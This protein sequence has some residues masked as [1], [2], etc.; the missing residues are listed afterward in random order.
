M[1]E[2]ATV[3]IL[4]IRHHGPGSAQSVAEA[5]DEIGPDCILVEG[6][7]ELT[8]ILPLLADPDTVPPIAGLVYDAA[9]PRRASFYPLASFSPEWVATRWGL[10]HDVPVEWTDLPAAA[11]LAIRAAVDEAGDR[12]HSAATAES[13]HDEPGRDEHVVDPIG[14]LAAAAGYDEPER[15]WEDAVEHRG[16][17]A[18]E[19][20]DGVGRPGVV[21][22]FDAVREAIAE[23]RA[24]EPV[25][26]P[27]VDDE[28]VLDLETASNQ[29]GSAM[30]AVREAAMRKSLRAALKAGRLRIAVVCGAWHAPALDPARMPSA[31]ADNRLLRGLPKT[32]VAAAWVPWTAT[33]LSQ[34]SGYGAGVASP[35]WYRHLF[36]ARRD[37]QDTGQA[38][39]SWMVRVARELRTQGRP[40]SPAAVVDAVRLADSLATLRGRPHPGLAELDDAALSVLADGDR[41]PLSLVN[42]ALVVG[43][44]VGAVPESAPLVPLAADLQRLQ[45]SCRLRPAAQAKSVMLDLRTDSGRAK[46]VLLHRLR[47][48]GIT[49]GLPGETGPTTGTFK[50][51][52]ELEWDPTM[53]VAVVEA[54]VYGTTVESAAAAKIAADAAEATDLAALSELIDG[55]L[56]AELPTG[57]VVAALADR[58]AAHTDVPDLLAAIEPLARVCRYGNVRQVTT[59]DVREVLD[60]TAVRACLGLPPAVAG[61]GNDAAVVL[62]TAIESAHRGLMLLGADELT[63]Y[64]FGALNRVADH[65]RAPGTLV[66]RATRMLLDADRVDRDEVER[67]MGLALAPAAD[68][69]DAAGWLDGFLAGDALVLMHDAALL[70]VVDRWMSEAPTTV[71]DDLL[72]LLRRT[73]SEFT[74]SERRIIGASLAR[75][76]QS[77]DHHRFDLAQAAPAIATVAALIGGQSA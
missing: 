3:S 4:G 61:L 7:G 39:A 27:L 70:A 52:W 38:A 35:G 50:E 15:W 46:S 2:P 56:L 63:E 13:G 12:R 37:G 17:D 19:R 53:A 65:D 45:R 41:L 28:K 49:W 66:G 51:A 1:T 29:L 18:T 42:D 72:P 55:C 75:T 10:A 54:S 57:P 77:V 59:A 32:K 58:A 73:F 24:D 71:F 67:R 33:R 25:P 40:A 36:D 14:A 43:A 21:D 68:P 23:L 62:R 34:W 64:W 20:L 22:R 48:L 31:A 16:G 5:L 76:E 6:P 8:P 9:V 44:D 26:V 11:S 74:P 60:Q 69:I 30:T 47:A